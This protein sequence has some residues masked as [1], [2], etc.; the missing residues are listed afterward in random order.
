MRLYKLRLRARNISSWKE[1]PCPLTFWT[2]TP[3][4]PICY[5]PAR[6]FQMNQSPYICDVDAEPLHRYRTGG[7]H[8]VHIGDSLN[9]NRYKILHKLGWGS[10]S[11]VWAARDQREH[12]YVAVKISISGQE[13][14]HR[15]FTILR[16]LAAA[17]SDQPGSQHLMTMSDHFQL[18]GPN[19]IHDCFVL[20]L[21]GPSVA[22]VLDAHFN[23]ERL[24]GKL[25]RKIA[26]QTLLGLSCLHEQGIGHADLHTR[27]LAFTIPSVQVLREEELYEKLGKP[28]TAY[29]QRVDR[30]PLEPG[31]PRY[32]VEPSSYSRINS[33][34]LDRV[35]IVDFGQSFRS[36]DVPERFYVPLPLQA[37]EI[38]FR[39]RVDWRVDLW[40]MGCILFEL[41][42]GQ[43]LFDSFMTTPTILVR[44]MLE[45][46]SDE[47]P[48]RWQ[49][50]WRNMEAASPGEES[51]CSLQG[52]LDEMYF[53]GERSEDLSRGD[54]LQVGA[55]IHRMLWF[56]PR[57]RASA[58]EILQDPWLHEG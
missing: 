31:I 9:S 2:P 37:P 41:V 25:A 26:K 10:Y 43:P 57:D 48:E 34:P 8:P 23:N 35:K 12:T 42:V 44:Q 7:Y 24:P 17:Q 16:S 4:R 14:S 19:G 13:R 28:K 32:L 27:N 29:V 1:L 38:V 58:K 20:E 30:K 54:I 45:L 11:T 21:L 53:D 46:A 49:E 52:W 18:N 39:D 22:D 56:E 15:E 6:T 50:Q 51:A 40:S 3:S 47:L 36:T 33:F 55:L 5:T